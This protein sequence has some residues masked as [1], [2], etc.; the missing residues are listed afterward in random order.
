[1]A[2]R[3]DNAVRE[4]RV[5]AGDEVER[6]RAAGARDVRLQPR[7]DRRDVDADRVGRQVGRRAGG[8]GAGRPWRGPVTGAD[9]RS[10]LMGA[11]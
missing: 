4:V 1:M 11:R 3:A 9:G 10:L 5:T 7:G 8:I 2:V 6:E